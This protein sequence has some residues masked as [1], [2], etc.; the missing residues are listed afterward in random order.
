MLDSR[1]HNIV[2][3]EKSVTGSFTEGSLPPEGDVRAPS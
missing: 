1:P 2:C 3:V